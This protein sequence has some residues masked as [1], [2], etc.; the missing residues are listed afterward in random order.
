MDAAYFRITVCAPKRSVS[1]SSVIMAS[2]TPIEFIRASSASASAG[3][4]RDISLSPDS[5]FTVHKETHRV[6]LESESFDKRNHFFVQEI[7]V[8]YDSH[9]TLYRRLLVSIKDEDEMHRQF[10]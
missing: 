10:G 5:S 2:I 1:L 7:L 3:A 9:T 6:M 4:L 8:L